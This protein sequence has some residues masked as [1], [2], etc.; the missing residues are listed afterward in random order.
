MNEKHPLL[1]SFIDKVKAQIKSKEAQDLVEYEIINHIESRSQSYQR[2]G[3]T[4]EEADKKTINQMGNPITF[5]KEMNQLHRPRIDWALIFLVTTIIGIS[6]VPMYTLSFIFEGLFMKKVIF[7][8]IAMI[9]IISLMFYDYR[10]LEKLGFFLYIS[11]VVMMLWIGMIGL[12]F[13]G[14]KMWHIGYIKIDYMFSLLLFYISWS[15]ILQHRNKYHIIILHLLFWLPMLLYLWNGYYLYSIIYFITILVLINIEKINSGQR[16]QFTWSTSAFGLILSTVLFFL[17]SPYQQERLLA[18]LHPEQYKNTFAY[19]SSISREMIAKAGWLGQG[20]IHEQVRLPEA[21]TD[22]I[23][24][25]ITYFF[26]WG[27][28]LLLTGILLFFTVRMVQVAIKTRHHYGKFIVIG[29]FTIFLISLLIN[30]LM[31]IG[32]LP[33]VGIPLPFISYG[34]VQLIF[35]S[36]IVGLILSVYRREKI[37]S[38]TSIE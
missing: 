36:T 13:Q 10:K 26:G 16:R 6:L 23:L 35:Y 30:M 12:D 22:L 2:D 5:G 15:S 29:G 34:G 11:S 8:L 25:Y 7:S 1:Q 32:L 31:S 3:L 38:L 24:P 21:H 18:F 33:Y 27:G 4:K 19:H 14:K 17:S 28:G 37:H 20:N 9:I